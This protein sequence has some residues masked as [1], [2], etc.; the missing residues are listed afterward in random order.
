MAISLGGLANLKEYVRSASEFLHENKYYDLGLIDV[1]IEPGIMRL[2]KQIAIW[3][4]HPAI[5]KNASGCDET[6]NPYSISPTVKFW[7]PNPISDRIPF[8]EDQVYDS[9]FEYGHKTGIEG[10]RDDNQ[11]ALLFMM[12]KIA[13]A[14][15][16]IPMREGWLGDTAL[17]GTPPNGVA[18]DLNLFNHVDG[19]WKQMEALPATQIVALTGDPN[20]GV[21]KTAQKNFTSDAALGFIDNILAQASQ[22]MKQPLRYS[23]GVTSHIMDKIQ[24]YYNDKT[25]NTYNRGLTIDPSHI[26]GVKRR[27]RYNGYLIHELTFMSRTIEEY[28]T[29]STGDGD[30]WHK[31]NRIVF[32]DFENNLRFGFDTPV[33]PGAKSEKGLDIVN[34]W[35][36]KLEYGGAG[37]YDVFFRFKMD[38]KVLIDKEVMISQ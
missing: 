29:L 13:E 19:L 22:V 6:A 23:F 20:A 4:K 36:M 34:P 10:L 33:W 11:L 31:P 37:K 14:I 24:A 26:P 9:M 2:D 7:T 15:P 18:G 21:T 27:F 3:G 28:F 16:D 5:G 25:A 30:P 32:A 8:C 38:A 17:V 12:G 35:N 1:G